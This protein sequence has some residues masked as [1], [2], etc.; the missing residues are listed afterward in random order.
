VLNNEY[1]NTKE[2]NGQDKEQ[3]SQ[4]QQKET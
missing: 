3:E 1:D 4:A 2:R